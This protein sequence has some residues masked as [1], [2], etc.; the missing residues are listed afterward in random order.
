MLRAA[1]EAAAISAGITTLTID[2]SEGARLLFERRISVSRR[3]VTSRSTASR[4]ITTAWL[5]RPASRT[6]AIRCR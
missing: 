4:H 3:V 6:R 1:M 2:A 5:G